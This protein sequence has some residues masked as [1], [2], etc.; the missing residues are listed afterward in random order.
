MDMKVEGIIKLI[1]DKTGYD[2]E[3]TEKMHIIAIDGRCCA[4]KTTLAADLSRLLE[5]PVVHMDHFFLRPNQ[6]TESRLETPGE[7]VDH[8]RFYDEVIVPLKK[9][10]D[11]VYRPFDCKRQEL[12]AP[13]GISSSRNLVIVEG[14]YSCHPALWDSYVFRIFM[15]VEHQTQIERIR[16]RN[17]EEALKVFKEKWIPLEEKYF[18]AFDIE[19]RCELAINT[20]AVHFEKDNYTRLTND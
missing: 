9:G 15:T 18:S 3:K 10:K 17:G 5:C 16:I 19:K 1:K 20:G 14:S 4:G 11:F 7:N 8:E 12:S 2:I 6:R 13:V